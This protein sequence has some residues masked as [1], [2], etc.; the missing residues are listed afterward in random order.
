MILDTRWTGGAAQGFGRSG[1]ARHRFHDLTLA[2]RYATHILALHDG[3]LAAFGPMGDTLT[4]SLLRQV[5]DVDV[6]ILGSGADAIVDF[7]GPAAK[8]TREASKSAKH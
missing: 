2:A 1:K 5:F 4:P 8:V 7:V 3:K 6:Q